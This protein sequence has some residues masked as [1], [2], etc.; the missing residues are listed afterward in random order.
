[1]RKNQI[2]LF[3]LMIAQVTTAAENDSVVRRYSWVCG[4]Q[5]RSCVVTVAD[6]LLTYYRDSRDHLA[7]R[8]SSFNANDAQSPANY[9]GFMFSE[10]GREV[11]RDLSMQLVDDTM[12]MKEKIMSLLTFVQ[13]IPYSK[14]RV[15]KGKAEYVRYPV[16][17]LADGTGDCEDKA[18]LLGSLFEELCVDFILMLPP[19]HMALG[20]QCDDI[21]KEQYFM[22]NDKKYYYLETT[23]PR[24]EIG[25]IPKEY[26]KA[27][28]EI[29]P[30]RRTSTLIVKGVK[31]NSS[32]VKPKQ[33]AD[34]TLQLEL[35]NSGPGAITGLHLNVRLV[36]SKQAVDSLGEAV[37]QLEDLQEG[38]VRK[39]TLNFKSLI[40]K[41]AVIE[42]WLTG[43]N[44]PDQALELKLR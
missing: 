5:N 3:I 13:S 4:E 25:Q 11:I 33:E 38:E 17:T 24:W 30:I 40:S 21:Q 19:D 31:F 14:D 44:I 42:M 2:L 12:T 6:S 26:R 39:E 7:Y 37:F 18:V 16:E 29:Y 36:K 10:P 41:F 8:Y 9:F 23:N 15:S 22:F 1:M 20:V 32:P 43:D 35:I 28:F 34:C 27:K